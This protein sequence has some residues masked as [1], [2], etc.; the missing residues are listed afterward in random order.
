MANTG[1]LSFI[2]YG[3]FI[4]I[5]LVAMFFAFYYIKKGTIEPDKLDKMI[6]LFKYSIVTTA[7]AT[8]TLIVAD[9]FKE[10]E[11][12]KN[13]M[14]AFNEY[15]PY[16]IDTTG[17]LDK[18]INFCKFFSSVTPK[19]E[20]KNGW[21]TYTAY[22]E[23]EKGKLNIIT[24][25]SKSTLNQ[26]ENKDTP[27]TK[28]EMQNLE[29]AEIEKQK[30]LSNLNAVENT[31]YLVIL[32]ADISQGDAKPELEWATKIN[33]NASIY[34]KGKWYRTAIALTN[35]QD[36]KTTADKIKRESNGKRDA[37]VVS[38]KTWC[39]STEF[40]SIENCTICN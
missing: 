8:V 10:R 4:L 25:K 17:T 28:E 31:I 22:L 2:L 12:D 33:S 39:N 13:E 35:Y 9:L 24:E 27:P 36:A 14:M 20:L 32:G 15:I 23:N 16:V 29:S 34:K 1:T 40:S 26:I 19:G 11:Y 18:K 37:Y 6:E 5:T 38:L 21:I 7:I 30:I 3:I